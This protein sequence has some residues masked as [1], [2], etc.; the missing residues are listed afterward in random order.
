MKGRKTMIAANYRKH[1]G[2]MALQLPL[3]FSRLLVW[4]LE[5]PTTRAL[6]AIRV[7]RGAAFKMAGRIAYPVAKVTPAWVREAT[8][9][10]RKLA[11]AVKAA[12]MTLAVTVHQETM[13]ERSKRL[14]AENRKNNP[15]ETNCRY[16]ARR[17]AQ[18]T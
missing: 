4:A 13:G 10:A 12:C 5:R 11:K 6:R 2:A 8:S 3:P 1:P 14:L 7:A 16:A 17:R 15:S 9:R 18:N